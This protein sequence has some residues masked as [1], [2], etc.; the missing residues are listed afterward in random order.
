[1]VGSGRGLIAGE[2]TDTQYVNSMWEG[3][4]FVLTLRVLTAL[5]SPLQEATV[6]ARVREFDG[7]IRVEELPVRA[8]SEE[9]RG[10][11]AS[12][13][14]RVSAAA[15]PAAAYM[16]CSGNL[17]QR[18]WYGNKTYRAEGRVMIDANTF[19]RVA[20]D[21]LDGIQ[22]SAGIEIEDGRRRRG[23]IEDVAAADE[24]LSGVPD[25]RLHLCLPWLYG[26][27]FSA[28]QWGEMHVEDIE[29]I[30]FREDAFDKL[31]LAPENKELIR[32]LVEHSDG[33]FSDIIESKGGGTIF[34]L[35]GPPGA[36]KTLTAEAVAELLRRPLYSI[37]V[38]ELGT[39]PSTLETSLR[40][41]LDV[42]T[43]WNAV[44]L[45]DEADIFL[46]ARD[47][48]SI[49]RNAMVGVFLRLLEYHQGT[50]F[51]TT[52][53]VRQFDGAFH[54]R[55]SVALR[56]PAMDRA[57]RKMVWTNLLA[58]AKIEGLDPEAL[59]A[60]EINGRQIKTSIRM[61]QAL[62]RSQGTALSGDHIRRVV[63]LA[64]K[65]AEESE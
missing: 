15:S 45:L 43:I 44:I 46:E 37:S 19:R 51:L 40:V 17:V 3:N 34:L 18:S 35:H 65:F 4:S 62:A 12:R 53:R 32:S 39:D 54:S 30:A 57:A 52:N 28:K 16:R 56:Y 9:D 22:R 23:N 33:G 11:L 48:H 38:G 64:A 55:I 25:D 7:W 5:G 36:G 26:F 42:A 63:D 1:M 29:D 41:I 27:S 60:H 20:M 61:A 50:L 13:G 21:V 59:S 10:I 8:L 47:E 14:R 24:A 6:H 2:I 31:V 49:E 58:A